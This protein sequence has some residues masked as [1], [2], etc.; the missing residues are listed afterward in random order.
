MAG[1]L[2]FAFGSYLSLRTNREHQEGANRYFWWSSIRLDTDPLNR[3]PQGATPCKDAKN[4]CV[5]WSPGFISVEPGL[6]AKVFVLSATPAFV[7][8]TF[9]V[10]RFARFGISELSSFMVAMPLLIAAWFYVV[11]WLVDRSI[12]KKPHQA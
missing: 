3:H 2:Y 4:D 11:G 10:R 8:G 7:V 5:E 1:L 12:Y 6:M 9:A